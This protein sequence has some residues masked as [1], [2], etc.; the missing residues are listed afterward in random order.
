LSLGRFI[1]QPGNL[2][3]QPISFCRQHRFFGRKIVQLRF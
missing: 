2:V 3:S 1:F